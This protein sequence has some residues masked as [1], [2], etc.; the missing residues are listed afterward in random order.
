VVE[1]LEGCVGEVGREA[2]AEFCGRKEVNLVREG[3]WRKKR[4]RTCVRVVEERLLG[5]RARITGPYF[6]EDVSVAVKGKRG[7]GGGK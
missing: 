3:G 6:V 2:R 4:R 1:T 5:G 7:E